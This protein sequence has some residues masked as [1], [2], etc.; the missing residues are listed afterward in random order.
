M[1]VP[2]YEEIRRKVE[3]DLDI[4]EELFVSPAELM[5]YCNEAI[6]EAEALIHKI[7]ED[8]FLT[9]APIHLVPNRNSYAMPPNIYGTK[10]RGIHY[11]NGSLYYEVPRL[12]DHRK[13][14]DIDSFNFAPPG[15]QDYF[16]YIRNDSVQAGFKIVFLPT[17]QETSGTQVSITLASPGV[18][19]TAVA[20][21]LVVGD[22]I[23][24]SST[25]DLPTG[26]RNGEN[27]IV[28]TVPS[29]TTF[30][31]AAEPGGVEIET[32]V[33]QSGTHYVEKAPFLMTAWYLRSAFRVTDDADFI[34]IPEFSKYI[35]Q[36]MK[37]RVYEKE[38]HPNLEQS[39]N[40]LNRERD[41]MIDTLTQMVPDNNDKIEPDMSFYTEHL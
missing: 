33:S 38:G 32:T 15:P 2:T 31:V 13:F 40:D 8:Y 28:S 39:V 35:I 24:L 19:S 41:L 12:R 26:L 34:D 29:T 14:N 9:M 20:H 30:T 25:G 17:P 21:G 36:Y 6:E 11:Q 27:Y 22:E 3:R 7:N 23:N 1:R 5:G 18:F 10:I 16:Y 37:K 4:E